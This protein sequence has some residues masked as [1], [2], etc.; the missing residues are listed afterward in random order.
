ME[1]SRSLYWLRKERNEIVM[2]RIWNE[3]SFSMAHSR[4]SLYYYFCLLLLC[5]RLRSPAVYERQCTWDSMLDNNKNLLLLW[6]NIIFMY[7]S[8]FSVS[9]FQFLFFFFS[10]L[11]QAL[12][13]IFYVHCSLFYRVY[14]FFFR[15]E[16]FGYLMK[17]CSRFSSIV[18]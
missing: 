14:G 4:F 8:F 5:R 18:E 1:N 11:I 17:N 9:T 7:V 13:G 2:C 6:L 10:W 3:I 12:S 16:F 15:C